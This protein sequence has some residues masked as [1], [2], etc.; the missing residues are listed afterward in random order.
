MDRISVTFG[1]LLHLL[2]LDV[3]IEFLVGTMWG[4]LVKGD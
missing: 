2:S 3:K 1:E 4:I